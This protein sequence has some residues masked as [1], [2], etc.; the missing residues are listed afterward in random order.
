MTLLAVVLV[1]AGLGFDA[2][3]EWMSK[4]S[5]SSMRAAVW[6]L[7]G[8]DAS[9]E[10]VIF[11][12]G[13]GGGG[14]VEAN[15]DRWFGQFEQPDGSSTRDHATITERTVNGLELTIA[16]MRGTFV[17]PVRPGAPQRNNSAGHR[18][19]AAVVE[20]ESGPWYIRVLGPEATIATWESSVEAFLSS[21]RPE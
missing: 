7:P 2:P 5:S 16:D 10:V 3:A 12:F 4:P 11:Y 17:A 1:A 13:E 8:D 18:M 15:L 20:G 6:E 9:A 14:G 21:L 19:I